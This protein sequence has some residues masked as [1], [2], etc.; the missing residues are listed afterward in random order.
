MLLKRGPTLI[1]V[2]PFNSKFLKQK[3]KKQDSDIKKLVTEVLP[4]LVERLSMDSRVQR[5][6]IFSDLSFDQI[7]GLSSKI[8][9]I[10][11]TTEQITV[12]EG[13]IFSYIEATRCQEETLVIYNPL[14]PFVSNEKI[15][16]LYHRVRAG[17]ANSAIGSY[18]SEQ[19]LQKKDLDAVNDPGIISVIDVKEFVSNGVRLVAPVDTISLSALELV[20]LRSDE[21][22]DLYDLIVNSGLV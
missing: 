13:V 2:V 4:G 12:A 1:V 21:D 6:D 3:Y 11:S 8:R 5:I 15:N 10:F 7:L 9:T 14:F 17:E 18:F 19:A 20:S 16:F 22:Y